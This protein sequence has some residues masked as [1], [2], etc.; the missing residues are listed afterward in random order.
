MRTIEKTGQF[1]RDYKREAKGQHRATLDTEFVP[2]LVALANDVP[3][4]QRHH[5]HGLTGNWSDHRD[6]HLK[7][8]LVLIYRKPDDDTLQLVRLGSHSELGL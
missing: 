7:P 1:K 6:C 4:E 5:D 2:V 8:D 3:L